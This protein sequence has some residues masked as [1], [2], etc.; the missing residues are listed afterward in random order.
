LRQ[1]IGILSES[2]SYS[3][4]KDRVLASKDFVN[5]ILDYAAAHKD[6]IMKT[7]DEAA[8]RQIKGDQEV[9]LRA[10]LAAMPGRYTVL[11]Y[12][13]VDENGKRSATGKPKEY[14]VTYVG[15][16]ES[17]LK[18][19][20]PAAYLVPR[21]FAQA[22]ETLRR[23]GI[24]V[25][26]VAKDKEFDVEVYKVTKF[27]QSQSEYQ[28]HKSIVNVDVEKRSEKKNI[29]AGEYVLVKTSQPLGNLTSFLLEPK[30]EDGL[31]TWNYFDEG[32]KEGEDFPVLRVVK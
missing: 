5:V 8:E 18:V 29:K 12:D 31:T 19:A 13:E 26:D 24:A 14:S 22:I 25:E 4:Y 30:A 23:H 1:R 16:V 21:K 3:S 7:L 32:L 15:G 11:G 27:I 17:T 9:T 10:K 20:R 6:E 28:K 2:Y